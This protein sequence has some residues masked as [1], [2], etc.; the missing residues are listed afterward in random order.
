VD[1]P[2]S[3]TCRECDFRGCAGLA[4]EFVAQVSDGVGAARLCHHIHGP[5]LERVERVF[6]AGLAERAHDDHGKRVMLHQ[7]S[8]ECDAIHA[9]H[10]DIEREHI[11]LEGEN[12]VACDVG[13][14]SR[15]DDFDVGLG[16]ERIAYELAHDCGVVHDEDTN[17]PGGDGAHLKGLR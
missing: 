9:R 3:T 5:R 15:G 17:F 12:L 1:A 11:R 14:D 4:H 2:S 7:D 10:L 6:R 16:V 13:I 8:Q